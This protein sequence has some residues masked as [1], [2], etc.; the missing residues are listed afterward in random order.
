MCCYGTFNAISSR[1]MKY[2]GYAFLYCD[3]WNRGGFTTITLMI[4]SPLIEE[5]EAHL[6]KG[7][8][9]R[10]VV[11][12]RERFFF[13]R[14]IWQWWYGD[15]HLRAQTYTIFAQ[16]VEEDVRARLLDLHN[17]ITGNQ[18]LRREVC[19]IAFFSNWFLKFIENNSNKNHN[20][21]H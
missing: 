21:I 6:R 11:W 13:K 4:K 9:V 8:Y 19:L 12:R 1:K 3:F 15:R 5:H 2:P 17:T 20:R 18:L 10:V 14:V 16:I 7:M